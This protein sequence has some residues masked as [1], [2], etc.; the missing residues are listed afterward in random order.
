MGGDIRILYIQFCLL[1]IH[2]VA[3]LNKL[4]DDHFILSPPFN[5]AKW[6]M[7]TLK[8]DMDIAIF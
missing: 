6:L 7:S 2:C 5:S 3:K 1:L 8:T 4:P